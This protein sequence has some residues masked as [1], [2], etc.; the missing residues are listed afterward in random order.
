MNDDIL[1]ALVHQPH[2][3]HVAAEAEEGEMAK[4]QDPAI[5]PDQIHGD[6]DQAQAQCLAEDLDETGGDKPSPKPSERTVTTMVNRP[7]AGR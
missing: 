4:R 1:G 2:A 3:D 7:P 6:G 5:A